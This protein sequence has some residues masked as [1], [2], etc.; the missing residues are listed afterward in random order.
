MQS[1]SF[2]F[3]GHVACFISYRFSIGCEAW[4]F[5]KLFFSRSDVSV[6]WTPHPIE[7]VT[8]VT[9]LEKTKEEISGLDYRFWDLCSKFFSSVNL[10][11]FYKTLWWK[12]MDTRTS[13]WSRNKQ[14]DL[15]WFEVSKIWWQRCGQWVEKT[16]QI[17]ISTKNIKILLFHS[18][19]MI[20]KSW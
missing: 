5:F 16:F 13:F 14:A 15:G 20:P 6:S 18:S 17:R 8:P 12:F 7:D 9:R 11:S 4:I 2:V 19:I 3:N 1:S 10:R